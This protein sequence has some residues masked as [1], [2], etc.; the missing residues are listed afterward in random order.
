MET[1]DSLAIAQLRGEVGS[2]FK[3]MHTSLTFSDWH[4]LKS[5]IEH[6]HA[7]RLVSHNH[8][9]QKVNR[10]SSRRRGSPM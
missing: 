10:A 9:I 2:F 5:C 8:G 6:V 4:S 7:S 1:K 3:N